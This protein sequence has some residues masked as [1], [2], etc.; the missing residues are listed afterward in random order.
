MREIHVLSDGLGD[1]GMRITEAVMK[2]FPDEDYRTRIHRF[3]RSEELVDRAVRE[4]P[5]D[6]IVF[7]TL[8]GKNI[9]EYAMRAA[10]PR[11]VL[12]VTGYVTTGIEEAIGIPPIDFHD[13]FFRRRD[14]NYFRRIEAIEF[15]VR[16]DDGKDPRGIS[17]A[18]VVLIGVSR[19][20]KTP[21]SMFL[22]NYGFKVA[23]LPLVPEIPLPKEI[24]E[25]DRNRI[26]GLIIRPDNLNDIRMERLREMGLTT[27]N[28]SYADLDR[29][30]DELVY[31]RGVMDELGAYV[32]DV[33]D[34][35]IEETAVVIMNQLQS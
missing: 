11:Q 12:D 6:A 15:A 17:K 23:N 4:M 3:V 24:Y 2:Q 28:S 9:R 35:N 34:K 19:T 26:F 22:A 13:P 18:D 20:S 5:E 31:A 16:Y 25:K 27:D 14:E 8:I 29:I 33:S 10:A 32:I 21:T 7:M 30:R 1:S